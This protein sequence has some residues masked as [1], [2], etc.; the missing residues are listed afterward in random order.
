MRFIPAASRT[1]S[2]STS[3]SGVASFEPDW[4]RLVQRINDA[5]AKEVARVDQDRDGVISAVEGD[6]DSGQRRVRD[7]ARLFLPATRYDRFAVTREIND[8]MLAPR[9]A[10]SQRAVG[11]HRIRVRGESGRARVL[12]A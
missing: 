11:A 8:G 6:V 1:R 3:S 7:N 2:I 9:F 4:R 5:Y 10:N 12:R